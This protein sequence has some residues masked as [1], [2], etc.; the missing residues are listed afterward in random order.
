MIIEAGKC[1]GCGRCLPYCPVA[2]IELKPGMGRTPYVAAV[3]QDGCVECGEC[4]KSA[5]CPTGAHSQPDLGWPRML[6]AM[7]SDPVAVFPKTLMPG[8]GTQEMKTN[9]ITNRF[10]EGEVGVGVELG[11]PGVGARLADAEKVS[12]RLAGLGVAFETE[13]PWTDLIDKTTGAVRD[14]TVLSERVLSC[15]VEC[16]CPVERAPAVYAALM[17]AAKEVDT[18]FTIDFISRC[19]DGV[20]EVAPILEKAGVKVRPNGKTNIGIG[21]VDA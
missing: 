16:K 3:D 18:V 17:E 19:R 9:D 11:R 4:R 7:W 10:R 6:R 1:T 2:A 13:S 12:I 21:R 8:R 15:I 20:P 5:V 14:R